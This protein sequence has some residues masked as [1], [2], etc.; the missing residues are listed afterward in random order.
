MG[1]DYQD[2]DGVTKMKMTALAAAALVVA[3][4]NAIAGSDHYG[5]NGAQQPATASDNTYTSS[6]RK[7]NKDTGMPKTVRKPV[8]NDEHGQGIWGH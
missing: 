8:S 1:E 7:M 2:K 4:G 6:T 5:S 3:A